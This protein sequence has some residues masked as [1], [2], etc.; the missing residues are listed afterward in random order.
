LNNTWDNVLEEAVILESSPRAAMENNIFLDVGSGGDS[1]AC[2]DS[3]SLSGL[4]VA[5][6]D[7]FMTHGPPGNYC[8]DAPYLSVDPRFVNASALDFHLQQ[9]SL[10]IDMALTL[11]SVPNDYEGTSRPQGK[12]YDIG[13]FEFH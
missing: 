1:Y 12:G 10:L 7:H 4:V 5:A 6:N 13:A 2:V 11:T 8:S 9:S 3:A